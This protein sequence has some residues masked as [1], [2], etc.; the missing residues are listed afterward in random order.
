MLKSC[1]HEYLLDVIDV[2]TGALKLYE[3]LGFKVLIRKKQI[4]AKQ[5]GLNECIYMSMRLR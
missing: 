2:N 1:G 5:A 3:S 4:F